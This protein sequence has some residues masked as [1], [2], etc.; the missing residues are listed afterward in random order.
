M[1]QKP[2]ETIDKPVTTEQTTTKQ[3]D[4]S[5]RP[6]AQSATT[7]TK[8]A[9]TADRTE[10][11]TPTP[12]P[13]DE[14]V[15]LE[16]ELLSLSEMSEDFIELKY[17]ERAEFLQFRRRWSMALLGVVYIIVFFDIIFLIAVGLGWLS[18]L[19]EWLVRIIFIGNFIEVIGLARI[20]VDFL[21]KLPPTEVGNTR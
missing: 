7:S 8:A 12:S 6:T 18:Y 5:V 21:F 10:A 9:T 15:S 17:Q 3:A 11:T 13:L 20:V 19:D 16:E 4:T 14:A 1:A 2:L